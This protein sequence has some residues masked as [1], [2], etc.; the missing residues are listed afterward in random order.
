MGNVGTL[1]NYTY[2]TGTQTFCAGT[3]VAGVCPAGLSLENRPTNV[4]KN[5]YN[6]TLYYEDAKFSARVCG[7]LPQQ[8]SDRRAVGQP[9][10]PDHRPA[11]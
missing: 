7:L 11:G 1:L 2:V 6:T 9:G 8:L 5:A 4:S 3:P 10:Q